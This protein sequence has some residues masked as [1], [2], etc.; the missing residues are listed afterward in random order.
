MKTLQIFYANYFLLAGKLIAGFMTIGSLL[1]IRSNVVYLQRYGFEGA[2]HTYAL[3]AI[4][5]FIAVF[6]GCIHI[7]RLPFLPKHDYK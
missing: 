1:G 4:P 5:F 3:A 6:A 2:G 7:V